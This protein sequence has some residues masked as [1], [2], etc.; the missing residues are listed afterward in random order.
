MSNVL[1]QHMIISKTVNAQPELNPWWAVRVLRHILGRPM[2]FISG[3]DSGINEES[4]REKSHCLYYRL[5]VM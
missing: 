3:E 2:A 5:L 1:M 4:D